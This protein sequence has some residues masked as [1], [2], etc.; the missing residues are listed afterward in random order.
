LNR[1][2]Y[3]NL[4]KDNSQFIQN[5]AALLSINPPKHNSNQLEHLNSQRKHSTPHSL[6]AI[7]HAVSIS[8]KHTSNQFE[9]WQ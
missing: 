9:T 7:T 8:K 4:I 2:L 3:L 5:R 6:L 1:D